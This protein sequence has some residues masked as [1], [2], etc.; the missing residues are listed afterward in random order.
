MDI[1]PTNTPYQGLCWNCGL[2]VYWSTI[3]KSWLE[4]PFPGKIHDDFRCK[5]RRENSFALLNLLGKE[6]GT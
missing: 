1:L 2:T 4:P 3:Y 5:L 6:N